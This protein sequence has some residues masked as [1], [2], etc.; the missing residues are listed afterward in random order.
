MSTLFARLETELVPLA[1]ELREVPA[2]A[3][4]HVLARE[5]P[6]DRQKLVIAPAA[7]LGFEQGGGQAGRREGGLGDSKESSLSP[8][9]P[10]KYPNLFRDHQL[11][12]GVL[13][14]KP[15]RAI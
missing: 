8:R 4:M 2:A 5:F 11:R 7:S 12:G 13:P 3:P 9:L 14:R 10:V 15:S 1:S 6:L